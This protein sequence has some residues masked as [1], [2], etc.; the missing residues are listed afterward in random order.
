M[1]GCNGQGTGI[2]SFALVSYLP[3][4]LGGFLDRL[5]SDLVQE[6]R[7]RAHVTVLPPRPLYHP[8]EDAWQELTQRL[9]DFRPF[10]V[11]LAEIEIFPQTQVIYLSVGAGRAEL[12]RLH[13]ALDTGLFAFDEPFKYHPHLTLAQDL[14]PAQVADAAVFARRRWQEFPAARAFTVDRLTFVQNTSEDRWTDLNWYQ[15]SARVA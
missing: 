8:V 5:R 12:E 14:E 6:C 2:N 3:E 9:R 13:D 11:E 7:A 4:P 10:Q 1:D 15:L